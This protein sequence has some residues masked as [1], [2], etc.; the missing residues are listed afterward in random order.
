MKLTQSIMTKVIG[1][2][3]RMTPDKEADPMISHHEHIG[4]PMNRVDGWQKVRGEALFSAEWPLDGMTY[5]SVVCSSIPKG[6]I[7]RIDSEAAQRADGVLAVITHENAPKI[8]A[9]RLPDPNGGSN[10]ASGSN[11]P[12]M[13]DAQIA[14]DGQPVA[15]VVAQTQDQADYA[16][17]L[18]HVEYQAQTADLSFDVAKSKSVLPSIVIG[19]EPEVHIGDAERA[20]EE[21]AVAVDHIYRTPRHNHNAIEPHA[22]IAAWNEDEGELLVYDATQNLYG[23]RN[24][25]ALMF[26]IEQDK[27]RVVS[28]FVGGAFGG[29]GAMWSNTPL[30]AMAAKV[31]GRPVKLAMSREVVFRTVGGRTTTEQRVALGASVDGQLSALIHS[32]VAA[33]TTH[34]DWPEQFTFPARHLYAC[35][36]L[37]VSQKVTYINMVANTAMRA[38]GESIGTFALES[39]VD[40]LAVELK[41]DPVELRF[42]NEP[43]KDP[44]G[45]AEFSNRNRLEAFRRGAEQFGWTNAAP[46]TQ[47]EGKWLIGQGVASAYYPVIRLPGSASVRINADGTAKVAASAQEMGM[48]TATVQIQ[49]AAERLGLATDKVAFD[50]G[51]TN[52]PEA[53]QAGG[54]SQTGSLAAAIQVVSEQAHRELLAMVARDSPLH[55]AKYEAI[56]ARDGG[57]FLQD[58]ASKGETYVSILGKAG[59]ECVETVGKSSPPLETIK[60]S[61][62]SYG[63]QFCEVRVHEETG[64]VRISRWL[65]VFDCGRILNPKT[66]ASQLRGGIIMGIGLALTEETLFDE[67][68][69]RIMNPSLAEYHV[70]VNLDVPDIEI[71]HLDIPDPH[72]P[73][74]AHGVGEIGITGAG[75]AIANAVF[76]ATGKRVRELP[77]ML[78]KLM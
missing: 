47:R 13:Q 3:A 74:G 42:L 36:N 66:A 27:V 48:G 33:M 57:L 22:T 58:D 34:N 59:K 29:K 44:T 61:M 78:D 26:G 16:A 10:G 23:F 11:L 12:V 72:T 41:M 54:S 64:E 70:P 6:V 75:A 49:Q 21:A 38:P 19:Q 8:K 68:S 52:L 56:E 28:R 31:V 4:K 50:Y 45:G 76:N 2:A 67:R 7:T 63:A 37:T 17:S 40:E 43:T 53:A 73:L 46:H 9:P 51:D 62:H 20:L 65:G 39:A 24:D 1:T 77:I 32:G 35:P 55:G 69:G 30:C 18:L 14:W 15:V 71:I 60:Y 25:L 5:A